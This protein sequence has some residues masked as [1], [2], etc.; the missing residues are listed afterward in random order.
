MSRDV[1]AWSRDVSSTHRT[2]GYS[3]W[4]GSCITE[5]D[6]EKVSSNPPP[7]P[8]LPP[9][10]PPPLPSPLSPICHHRTFKLF[11]NVRPC[12]SI[13][14]F[15]T[16]YDNVD[17][18]TIRE[19]TEGLYIG[20]EHEV[21]CFL[22]SDTHFLSSS[23][24]L[25]NSPLPLSPPVQVVD[26]V[27][28]SIKLITREASLRIAKFAFEYARAHGRKKVASVHKANIMLAKYIF[29]EWVYF[30]CSS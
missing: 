25:F 19:N 6:T 9:P 11:A 2:S 10:P 24:L 13:A 1:W 17:L 8:P 12:R 15:K 5:P 18:V 3:N 14:G 20:I 30:C 29:F 16:A 23:S 28:Q 22:F 21:S 26:G 4:E 27:V 7:P